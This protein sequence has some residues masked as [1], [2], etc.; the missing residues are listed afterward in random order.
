MHNFFSQFLPFLLLVAAF[1][2]F[3]QNSFEKWPVV[4]CRFTK[5]LSANPR[6]VSTF[7]KRGIALGCLPKTL[8]NSEDLGINATKNFLVQYNNKGNKV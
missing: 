7:Q 5:E 3:S 2:K 1:P 4:A 8:A 6:N